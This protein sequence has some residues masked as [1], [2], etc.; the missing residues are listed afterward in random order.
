M[1]DSGIASVHREYAEQV[2][3]KERCSL[4]APL[5][6]WSERRVEG[7]PCLGV[8]YIPPPGFRQAGSG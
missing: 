1:T 6:A 4:N 5:G 8:G 2:T 7:K 3:E